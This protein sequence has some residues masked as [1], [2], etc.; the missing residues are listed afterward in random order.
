MQVLQVP[1][2]FYPMYEFTKNVAGDLAE[3]HTLVPAGME[4]HDWEPTPQDIASIEKADVLVY[5]GA[6]KA[7]TCLKVENMITI[8]EILRQQNTIMTMTMRMERLQMNTTTI[9]RLK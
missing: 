9:M 8:M 5:N 3:V 6:V 2:S 1:V 7:S 4:P